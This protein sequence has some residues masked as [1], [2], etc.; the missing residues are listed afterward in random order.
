MFLHGGQKCTA[1]YQGI[2]EAT[3]STESRDLKGNHITY[4]EK[5]NHRYIK[6]NRK[7]LLENLKQNFSDKFTPHYS[8]FVLS[9]GL[10]SSA[11]S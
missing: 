10:T 5:K 11:Y 8:G 3:V 9:L 6:G 4:V 2:T 1:A 7:Y